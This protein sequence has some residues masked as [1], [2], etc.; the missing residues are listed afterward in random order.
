MDKKKTNEVIA[1]FTAKVEHALTT[2]KVSENIQKAVWE[3]LNSLEIESVYAAPKPE[4][5]TKKNTEE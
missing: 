2:D 1:A 4:E 5:E 3:M